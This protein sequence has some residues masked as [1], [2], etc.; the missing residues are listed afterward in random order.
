MLDIGPILFPVNSVCFASRGDTVATKEAT[1]PVLNL[2]KRSVDALTPGAKAFIAFDAQLHGFGVRVMPSGIKT[3]ILEYRPNGGGRGV[4]KRRLKL[5]RF[6]PLTVD[7]A[8]EKARSAHARVELGVDPA[9]EKAEQRSAV[10]V[11]GLIDA[12]TA[13]HVETKCKGGTAEAHKAALKK[14]RSAFGGLKAES[15]TRSQLAALHT[16]M[17]SQPY[18]ANRFLA[19]VSKAF[20]WAGQRGLVPETHN[21]ASRIERYHETQR[22]RFLNT[23]EVARLGEALRD[24]E[25]VGL[26]WTVDQT[27]PNAKHAPKESN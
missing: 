21:P 20:N 9:A 19:V 8:R 10:T 24:A 13:E 23:A 22:E 26:P 2:T 3:F 6:G 1:M 11:G 7:G 4:S 16:K 12:F 5:G 17:R 14:L 27:K 15:L 18:A 25:S